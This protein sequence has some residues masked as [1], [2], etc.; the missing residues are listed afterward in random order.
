M[1]RTCDEHALRALVLEVP[2]NRWSRHPQCPDT[3]APPV[4]SPGLLCMVTCS[5]RFRVHVCHSPFPEI[6]LKAAPHLWRGLYVFM[7]F[8]LAMPHH[9]SSVEIIDLMCR[10][11]FAVLRPR[12]TAAVWHWHVSEEGVV[13][14]NACP[15]QSSSI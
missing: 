5:T 14:L 1:C 12:N 10:R 9:C 6:M 8:T 7:Y 4:A 11:L 3:Q 13:S 15:S 2:T